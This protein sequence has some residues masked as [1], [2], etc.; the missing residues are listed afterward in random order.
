MKM[1]FFVLKQLKVLQNLLANGI[2]SGAPIIDVVSLTEVNNFSAVNITTTPVVDS[3]IM[4]QTYVFLASDIRAGSAA[5]ETNFIWDRIP[6][7]AETWTDQTDTDE[8]W[9][10]VSNTLETL[11]PKSDTATTWT[12]A[13][14]TSEVWSDA[15]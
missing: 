1:V 6:V 12:A 14:D 5:I 9:A 8:S 3:A 2:L 10:V 7:T 15:A 4:G 13:A 11:N